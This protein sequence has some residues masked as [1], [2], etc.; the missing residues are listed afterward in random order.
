MA[1]LIVSADPREIDAIQML[2]LTRDMPA[3]K[4]WTG[5]SYDFHGACDLVLLS[6]PSYGNGQEMD[7]HIRTKAR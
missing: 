7:I 5:E 3:V 4:T 6:N 1:I 2:K